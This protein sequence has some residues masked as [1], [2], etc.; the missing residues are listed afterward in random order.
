MARGLIA[1]SLELK[2]LELSGPM[3]GMDRHPRVYIF[4][5]LTAVIF[6]VRFTSA[7]FVIS[8]CPQDVGSLR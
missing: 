2:W 7:I 4:T 8:I 5:F 1:P 6:Y 3:R